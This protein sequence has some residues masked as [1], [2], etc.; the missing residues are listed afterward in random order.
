MPEYQEENR[1]RERTAQDRNADGNQ[2]ERTMQI[3]IGLL[4]EWI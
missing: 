2:K 4:K 1:E 3:L